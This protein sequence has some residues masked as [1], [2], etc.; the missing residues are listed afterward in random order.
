MI[1][2]MLEVDGHTCAVNSYINSN[3]VEVVVMR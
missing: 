2:I 3:A 1:Q